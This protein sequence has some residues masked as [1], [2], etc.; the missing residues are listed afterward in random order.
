MSLS[1][2]TPIVAL[3]RRRAAVSRVPDG[4]GK[5]R[6]THGGTHGKAPWLCADGKQR[7]T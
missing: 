1:G 2:L 5:Q 7:S 3:T 4:D 6:S